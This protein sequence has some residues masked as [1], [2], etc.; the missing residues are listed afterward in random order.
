MYDGLTII[1]FDASNTENIMFNFCIKG[2]FD[3]LHTTAAEEK[4]L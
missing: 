1:L 2:A 4:N 3:Y